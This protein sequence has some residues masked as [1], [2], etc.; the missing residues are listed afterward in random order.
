VSL[1][2]F[3][4]QEY[5]E[6]SGLIYFGARF[7]DPEVG[8]FISQDSYLG[9]PG[10]PPSLHRYLYAYGN[11]TVY[12]DWDGY[13]NVT[14]FDSFDYNNRT[15][16]QDE[17]RFAGMNLLNIE[18]AGPADLASG[19]G[20]VAGDGLELT[21]EA[22]D[23]GVDLLITS[24][25]GTKDFALSILSLP[26]V[27][28]ERVGLF[29][30]FETLLEHL[31]KHVEIGYEGY[32]RRWRF[33]READLIES[34]A[35]FG[36]EIPL[37]GNFVPGAVGNMGGNRTFVISGGINAENLRVSR[38]R[39]TY[40]MFELQRMDVNSNLPNNIIFA[41]NDRDTATR[42]G[43]SLFLGF[44]SRGLE[45]AEMIVD[46]V[47]RGSTSDIYSHSGGVSRASIASNYVAVFDIGVRRLAGD[48]GP[49][50]GLYNNIESLQA[51]Y[52]VGLQEPTSDLGALLSFGYWSAGETDHSYFG[53]RRRVTWENIMGDPHRQLGCPR[54][55]NPLSNE[56]GNE[57][58]RLT[59]SFFAAP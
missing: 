24:I 47:D 20:E 55:L 42:V 23:G 33:S 9:E 37:I 16:F 36:Q 50:F 4:G 28:I 18:F 1:V 27:G 40:T 59:G 22:S 34:I 2:F 21:I 46:N 8:R 26:L 49:G 43:L 10:T 39:D 25:G 35:M 51:S 31:E 45:M 57:N 58:R 30:D 15:V 29:Q 53:N 6:N 52:S 7:Y 11:P 3:T 19:L 48:Q 41:D 38:E 56:I 12:I 32:R 5:D 14:Y 17:E 13:A 44:R 54:G